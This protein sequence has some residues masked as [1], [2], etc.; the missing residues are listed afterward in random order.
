LGLRGPLSAKTVRQAKPLEDLTPPYWLSSQAT[1]YWSAHAQHLAAN[2]LLT[3]ATQESFALLCDLYSRVVDCLGKETTRQ[4]LDTVKAYYAQAKLFRLVPCDKPGS[5]PL[6]RY[7]GMGEFEEESLAGLSA[8][9]IVKR[10]KDGQL[11]L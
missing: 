5:E 8:E 3:T 2:N 10:V 9:E 11:I 4:Y 7:D 1:D 6:T